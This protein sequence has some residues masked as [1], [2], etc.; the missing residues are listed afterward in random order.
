MIQLGERIASH[1]RPDSRMGEA[2]VA[3]APWAQVAEAR[4]IDEATARRET[5][6]GPKG[7][8]TTATRA[9]PGYA[10]ALAAL[11]DADPECE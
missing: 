5:A 9:T 4:G 1:C 7:C 8:T 3:G 6:S 11:N 10:D 2:V